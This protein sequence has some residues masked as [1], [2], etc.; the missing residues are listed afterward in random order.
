MLISTIQFEIPESGTFLIENTIENQEKV[1]SH[2]FTRQI[3][4]IKT[5]DFQFEREMRMPVEFIEPLIL[6][7]V[8]SANATEEN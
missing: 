4:F 1:F 5:F 7:A 2:R 6:I 8:L 3:H